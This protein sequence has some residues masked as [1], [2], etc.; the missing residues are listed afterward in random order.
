LSG[1]HVGSTTA[2]ISPHVVVASKEGEN[3][4]AES[5]TVPLTVCSYAK[6]GS[7]KTQL[8]TSRETKFSTDANIHIHLLYKHHG[9]TWCFNSRHGSIIILLLDRGGDGGSEGNY[10]SHRMNATEIN[11]VKCVW[12]RVPCSHADAINP[13]MGSRVW[14]TC[15]GR[16]YYEILSDT[17]RAARRRLQDRCV[18]LRGITA[19]WFAFTDRSIDADNCSWSS[20]SSSSVRDPSTQMVPSGLRSAS[21]GPSAFEAAQSAS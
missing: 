18:A 16:V 13:I 3:A 12:G 19:S 9:T 10:A 4:I 7:H 17:G 2:E 20:S 15:C 11:E 14:A 21:F 5:L 6:W 1:W 8:L